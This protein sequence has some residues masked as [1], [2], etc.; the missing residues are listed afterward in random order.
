VPPTP[1]LS[2]G[3]GGTFDFDEND[4]GGDLGENEEAALLWVKCRASGADGGGFHYKPGTL[5]GKGRRPNT[6]S[7]QIKG[8][9]KIE[10]GRDSIGPPVE[11]DFSPKAN[12]VDIVNVHESTILENLRQR[13]AKD[14]FM[15]AVGPILVCINPYKFHA[16][17]YG[18]DVIK[19]YH[20]DPSLAIEAPHV[21]DVTERA[22][23]NLGAERT[24]QAIL[25]SGESGA[26]KTETTKTCLRYLSEVAGADSSV[27]GGDIDARILSA[28]PVLEAFGNAKTLR[29]DNSSRFG[30]WLEVHFL[31]DKLSICGCSTI[32]YLL[33]KTRVVGCGPGERSYHVFYQLLASDD[34]QLKAEKLQL[35]DATTASWNDYRTLTPLGESWGPNSDGGGMGLDAEEKQRAQDARDFDITTDA[36]GHLGFG[37]STQVEIFRV[38]AG[39]LSLGNVTFKADSQGYAV[40]DLTASSVQ[41]ALEHA[42]LSFGVDAAEME[43]SLCVQTL[44][45]AGDSTDRRLL[46]ASAGENRDA[47]SKA[48]YGK[49]FDFLITRFNR[50][51]APKDTMETL[52]IGILDIFGFE[53]FARNSFEQLCINFANETLQQNFNKAVFKE[54][55]RA[56]EEEGIAGVELK[57]TDNQDVLDLIEA[58]GRRGSKLPAGLLPM[59]DEEGR[60]VG[61]S[62]EGFLNKA[63]RAHQSSKRLLFKA[64]HRGERTESHEFWVHHYA[65]YVKYDV[66]GF[67]DKNRDILLPDLQSLMLGGSRRFITSTL[68]SSVDTKKGPSA[69]RK[70]KTQ[71]GLFYSQLKSLM[72]ILEESTP[73]FI[74]CIKPNNVKQGR[75]FSAGMCN[76][77]LACSGVYEAVRIRKQGFPHRFSHRE[78]IRRYWTLAPGIVRGFDYASSR[79]NNEADVEQAQGIAKSLIHHLEERVPGFA[80]Q[81]GGSIGCLIGRSRIFIPEM[82]FSW[83]EKYRGVIRE[84]AIYDLQRVGRGF[85]GRNFCRSLVK[86]RRLLRAAI[87]AG[88]VSGA[89]QILQRVKKRTGKRVGLQRETRQIEELVAQHRQ[90]QRLLE[91]IETAAEDSQQAGSGS[92]GTLRPSSLWQNRAD[93]RAAHGDLTDPDKGLTAGGTRELTSSDTKLLKSAEQALKMIAEMEQIRSGLV[94][95]MEEPTVAGLSR[96]IARAADMEETRGTFCSDQLALARQLLNHSAQS[97]MEGKRKSVHK[98]P[99]LAHVRQSLGMSS[100][101][102]SAAVEAAVKKGIDPEVYHAQADALNAIGSMSGSLKSTWGRMS[103]EA[104]LKKLLLLEG[105]CESLRSSIFEEEEYRRW[106][107]QR[108]GAVVKD[109]KGR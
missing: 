76:R 24:T 42:A 30:K 77:Q 48:L 6:F 34:I 45:I 106:A 29:N 54:E 60:V 107:L 38:L 81:D 87:A 53:I 4:A 66:R 13:Y 64:P 103:N 23:R 85:T 9:D 75:V 39:I 101:A 35:P 5:L 7:F 74:R 25:I 41:V 59:L 20:E 56:C 14:Q 46:P 10:V 88:D 84:R 26:G 68:F 22:F 18:T 102:A 96:A 36:L 58:R 15:T 62:D 65:D 78:F 19:Q 90:R 31:H 97:Q 32:S 91:I 1:S 51:M 37:A 94:V 21:Y 28:N 82:H 95:A 108:L 104:K 93:M 47:L 86:S 57:F 109:F 2:Q 3:H 100:Q 79:P 69:T 72:T 16:S 12:M 44:V 99:P 67:V 71:G 40:V 83:L 73:Y 63:R 61:G 8:A 27:S 17:K 43:R 70:Q 80:K 50:E 98:A 92:G 33:E 52:V 89:Q 55:M 49:L 105:L 11:A